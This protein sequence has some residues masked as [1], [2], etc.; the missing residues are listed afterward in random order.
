MLSG[1]Q[2]TNPL[3]IGVDVG[4]TFT[5]LV[6]AD[7]DGTLRVVKVPSTPPDCHRAVL[8]AVAQVVTGRETGTARLV[9][10][11]TVATNALLQRAGEPVA[12]ITT[13]GFRDM[14][15]IGRQNRPDLY[16]LRVI[17]PATGLSLS[18]R[19]LSAMK[20]AALF[21]P[22]VPTPRPSRSSDAR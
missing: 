8:E 5:D 16:A 20:S 7:A 10:G 14:L 1:S 12:F 18:L 21:N 15:L 19:K 17:R 6:A 22:V 9:H 3:L 4:G 11:S 13:H 2:R